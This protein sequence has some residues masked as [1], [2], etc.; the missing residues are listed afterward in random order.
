MK[1][2]TQTTHGR[3]SLDELLDESFDRLEQK[4]ADIFLRRIG[5]L[6]TALDELETVLL[7][8]GGQHN[9]DVGDKAGAEG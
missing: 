5:K 7:S 8:K 9:R 1:L 2:D 4:Q 3:S 6:E